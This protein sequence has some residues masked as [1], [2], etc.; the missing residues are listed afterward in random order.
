[1][2][3]RPQTGMCMPS[4]KRTDYEICS[5][6]QCLTRSSC[7][8][9]AISLAILHM[10]RDALRALKWVI[11]YQSRGESTQQPVS[12]KTQITLKA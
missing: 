5:Q 8:R 2:L 1:M 11:A 10:V 6:V 4:S 9:S 7:P 3:G 12:C